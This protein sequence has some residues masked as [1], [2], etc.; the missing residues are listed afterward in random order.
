[1]EN[2]K[3]HAHSRRIE[4]KQ[5]AGNAKGQKKEWETCEE[6]IRWKIFG[7]ASDLDRVRRGGTNSRVQWLSA[8]TTTTYT[9]S[10]YTGSSH[11]IVHHPPFPRVLINQT[12][13]Q[14]S[15]I[16]HL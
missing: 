7:W 10:R 14:Q 6:K 2:V 5:Q 8:C 13:L 3:R 4:G 9:L 1:M 11:L 15:S 12:Y 16:T